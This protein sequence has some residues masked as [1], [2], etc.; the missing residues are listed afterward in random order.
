[1][2]AISNEEIIR[3]TQDI[4][5]IP[6]AS[7]LDPKKHIGNRKV[8]EYLS[9]WVN[10]HLNWQIIDSET[11]SNV[12]FI[13]WPKSFEFP[14]SGGLALHTHL[15]T[16]QA[17]DLK[18]W[19]DAQPF[20]AK[21]LKNHIVGLGAAD[22]KPDA[23][24]KIS[25]LLEYAENSNLKICP[26][27]I[28]SFSE[29]IGMQGAQW[30]RDHQI[31]KPGFALVGEPSNGD[32]CYANKGLFLLKA[33][34]E[35]EAEAYSGKAYEIHYRGMGGHSSAPHKSI[36]ALE[37][38]LDDLAY[39]IDHSTPIGECIGS[40][41]SNV[42][43]GEYE[44]RS[45]SNLI[46]NFILKRLYEIRKA[47]RQFQE[48]LQ[49]SHIDSNF[50]PATPS[51]AW[52]VLDRKSNSLHIEIEG[53]FLPGQKPQELIQNFLKACPELSLDRVS[54]S[55]FQD[56]ESKFGQILGKLLKSDKKWIT[57]SGSNESYFYQDLGAEVF[58]HGPGISYGNIHRPNEKIEISSILEARDFY[59]KVIE[60]LCL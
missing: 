8:A 15:D 40:I 13:C 59:K 36:N 43:P 3:R 12:T 52:T 28:G 44:W 18:Q 26:F 57:K 42:I 54:P 49:E 2:P 14:K 31:V 27:F 41:A 23:I 1:M 30:I 35:F 21:R 37:M 58:V 47:H 34:L 46:P 50:E 51:S 53:R 10:K 39:Q 16:V 38:A 55:C 19:T 60:R 48:S 17:G 5:R 29:E 32:L 6:S 24:C 20:E 45:S 9:Q 25:A 4:I 33:N 22:V 7:S 11:H 56:R